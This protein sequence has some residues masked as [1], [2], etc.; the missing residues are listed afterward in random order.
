MAQDVLRLVSE[1]V[2]ALAGRDA[3][4]IR[5][6]CSREKVLDLVYSDAE[7]REPLSAEESQMFWSAWFTAFPNDYDLEVKRTIA[8]KEVVVLQWVFTGTFEGILGPPVSARPI[9]PSGKTIQFR[10]VSIYDIANGLIQRE[11]I[12]MDLATWFVEVGIEP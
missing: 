10:A 6:L 9:A 12:Y 7:E 4:Q 2:E 1:Y 11:T 5:S 8:A 3:D